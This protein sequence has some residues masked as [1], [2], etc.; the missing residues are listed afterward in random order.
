MCALREARQNRWLGSVLNNRY[1]WVSIL[2]NIFFPKRGVFKTESVI[3]YSLLY[4]WRSMGQEGSKRVF[5]HA[6]DSLLAR[7]NVLINVIVVSK[8]FERKLFGVNGAA[9]ASG[10]RSVPY[11]N[12]RINYSLDMFRVR[13][14]NRKLL[15]GWC[16][17]LCVFPVIS[18]AA[19]RTFL[20]E[21][22]GGCL[23]TRACVF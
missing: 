23:C 9:G 7:L 21:L 20:F 10:W 14:N 17:Y 6:T 13:N 19:L 5:F 12:L 4:L 16:L 22:G 3:F 1:C 11:F 15:R 2:N 18:R 8:L